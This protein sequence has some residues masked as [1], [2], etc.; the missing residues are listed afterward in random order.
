[1]ARYEKG[2]YVKIEVTDQDSGDRKWTLL[3]VNSDAAGRRQLVFGQ[4]DC[5]PVVVSDMKR[6]HLLA[7]ICGPVR[8]HRRPSDLQTHWSAISCSGTRKGLS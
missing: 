6:G 3:L 5:D 2:D 8:D 1:M 4:L 7:V